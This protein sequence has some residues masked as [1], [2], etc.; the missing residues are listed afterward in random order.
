MA[1]YGS[2]DYHEL[3]QHLRAVVQQNA[4]GFHTATRGSVVQGSPAIA[5]SPVASRGYSPV[6]ENGIIP[7]HLYPIGSHQHTPFMLACIPAPWIPWVLF[8]AV[9]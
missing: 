4:T 9:Y 6:S 5:A 3:P 8:M 2:S 7:C 1:S